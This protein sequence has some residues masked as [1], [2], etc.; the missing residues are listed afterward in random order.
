MQRKSTFYTNQF[1]T[2][3]NTCEDKIFER[4]VDKLPSD[5]QWTPQN[6]WGSSMGSQTLERQTNVTIE[7]GLGTWNNDI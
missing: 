4:I 5:F 6:F 1:Y 3:S 2:L 7:A